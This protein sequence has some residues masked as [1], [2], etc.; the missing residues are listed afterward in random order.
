MPSG[1]GL[2]LVSDFDVSGGVT[3]FTSVCLFG[4][5]RQENKQCF[6]GETSSSRR[7][8]SKQSGKVVFDS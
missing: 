1:D 7:E 4:E 8:K 5:R 2:A 6:L 3:P